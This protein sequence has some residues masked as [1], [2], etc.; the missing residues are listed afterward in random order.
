MRQEL[1][2]LSDKYAWEDCLYGTPHSFSHTWLSNYAMHLSTGY[3]TYLY[4]YTEGNEHVICPLA[5]REF[6]GYKDI[7]TP[8]GF[9]GF[10]AG[11]ASP[12]FYS[13]WKAFMKEQGYICAYINQ[14]PFQEFP[15]LPEQERSDNPHY[16]YAIE[17]YKGELEAFNNLSQNR[18][19]QLKNFEQVKAEIVTD[20]KVLAE[21]FLSNYHESMLS[22]NA[23]P[24]YM[25]SAKTLENIIASENTS[26]F[27]YMKDSTV[28]AVSVFAEGTWNADY[29]FNVSLS[30]GKAFGS[31]LIW[32]A[33]VHY[34]EKGKRL[35]NLG[36]GV[37]PGDNLE[38]FKMRFGGIRKP[39]RPMREIFNAD[40][41][42]KLCVEAGVEVENSNYFPA[43][44]S[45]K[46]I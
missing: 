1:I 27:G 13:L 22:S 12:E 31:H 15:Q 45:L 34:I 3:I 39:L 17:L 36:G 4:H 26:L 33:V 32:Q 42:N 38:E 35:L 30:D 44:R 19:R 7:V 9:S 29:L 28:L 43:Y 41:Y 16:L 2:P 10:T 11:S 37:K 40:I 21:F 5:E 14:D 25:F 20:K 6:N 8:Y 18:K 46:R 24:V 23:S